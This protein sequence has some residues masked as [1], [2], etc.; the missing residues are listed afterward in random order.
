MGGPL[1]LLYGNPLLLKLEIL[2]L[3]WS[4]GAR[5]TCCG[6]KSQPCPRL[7]AL[8]HRNA[9]GGTAAQEETATVERDIMHLSKR[10]EGALCK[11]VA[12][13]DS[14]VYVDASSVRNVPHG[15]KRLIHKIQLL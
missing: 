10:R 7:P 11:P 3:P 2:L 13:V 15:R 5:T 1:Y 6:G 4:A 14:S 12:V 8:G 9:E